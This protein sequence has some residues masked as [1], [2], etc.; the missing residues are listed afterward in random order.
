MCV[1][2]LGS[3]WLS[4]NAGADVTLKSGGGGDIGLSPHR[5]VCARHARNGAREPSR[6]C[7]WYGASNTRQWSGKHEMKRSYFEIS[8][9][10]CVAFL[11][12]LHVDVNC[13]VL[14]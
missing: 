2:L 14:H 13:S 11:S 6:S 4:L 5:G 10:C 1:P 12:V 8:C 7:P 3:F 9:S